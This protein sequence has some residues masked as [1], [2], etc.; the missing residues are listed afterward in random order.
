MLAKIMNVEWKL[1]TDKLF[2]W[3]SLYKCMII[4]LFSS[5]FSFQDGN[6]VTLQWLI[7]RSNDII[8]SL[9]HI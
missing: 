7:F 6:V 8:L 3:E 4:P 5:N 1:L 9:A 2:K